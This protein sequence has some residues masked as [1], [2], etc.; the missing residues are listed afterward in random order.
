M[1]FN[2]SNQQTERKFIQKWTISWFLGWLKNA[3]HF[4]IKANY[5]HWTFTGRAIS[6]NYFW[7]ILFAVRWCNH[8]RLKHRIRSC[9]SGS[10]LLKLGGNPNPREHTRCHLFRPLESA[11]VKTRP[12]SW[13]SWAKSAPTSVEQKVTRPKNQI[14]QS[15]STLNHFNLI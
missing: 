15:Y 5:P 10:P 3:T 13:V 11:E 4:K 12:Q 1:V 8:L 9:L 2:T 14:P 7:A 6:P